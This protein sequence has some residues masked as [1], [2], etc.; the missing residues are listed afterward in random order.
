MGSVFAVPTYFDKDGKPVGH[1]V[2]F[3]LP[4]YLD[5]MP[6]EV[7]IYWFIERGFGTPEA[8]WV[9]F[10]SQGEQRLIELNE[11]LQNMDLKELKDQE[12]GLESKIN[13]YIE[14]EGISRTP[15]NQ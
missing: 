8:K 6:I 5:W 12:N 13:E 4:D 11:P 1:G 7:K 3:F 15:R 10:S 14:R 9:L 2:Q